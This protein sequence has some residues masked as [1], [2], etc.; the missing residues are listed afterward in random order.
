MDLTPRQKKA[1]TYWGV[2][3]STGATSTSQTGLWDAIRGEASARGQ[4]RLGFGAADLAKVVGAMNRIR[5]SAD[6]FFGAATSD[7][8][9]GG[10]MAEAPWSRSAESQAAL[11]QYQVRFVHTTV[12]DA[13]NEQ[14]QWLTASYTG[15][16]PATVGGLYDD[17]DAFAEAR[18]EDYGMQHVSVES[19]QI[20][21]I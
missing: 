10:M 9:T 5:S 16:L 14:L 20:L 15:G 6:A 11:P 21:R 17:I 8:I 4:D 2:I 13:G 1:L 18:A 12:D 19:L 7:T 3:E